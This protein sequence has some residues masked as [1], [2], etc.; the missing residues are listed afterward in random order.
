MKATRL[1]ATAVAAS[2]LLAGC[3]SGY[4]SDSK[5]GSTSSAPIRI[6]FGSSGEAETGAVKAAAAAWQ[7][8][9]GH[10]VQVIPAQNLAQQLTQGFAG[11][12]PPDIFYTDPTVLQQYAD[13]GS[14]YP[15]GD[16]LPKSTVDDFYPALKQAYTYQD[17]LYCAPK[18]LDTHE[19]VINTDLWKK[20]GL[21]AA[22]YPKTW[23]DL[24]RVATKLTTKDH[25]GL[26]VGGDHN[27]VGTFMLEAGGW[28]VNDDSTKVTADTPQN[29][30]ALKYL[31]T[32]MKKKIF[33]TPKSINTQNPGEAFGKGKAAMDVDGGWIIGQLSADYP[34]VNWTAVP[35]PAGPSGNGTTVFSNCWGIAAKSKNKKLAVDLVKSLTSVQQQKNFMKAF[36]ATP[37]RQS[38]A[39]WTVKENPK[40]TAFVRGVTTARGVVPIPGFGSVLGDFDTQLEKLF[41]GGTDPK[42][43]LTSLQRNGTDALK[44]K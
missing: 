24:T 27:T 34:G 15:Y 18:D 5:D 43:A 29:L 44:Q 30:A 2:L 10:K 26:T 38:L 31:Q 7:K 12:N 33:A 40:K 9:T 17:K 4:D 14:L 25:V 41:T 3:G 19:L 21:T 8:K 39:D 6:M 20:A 36:G 11:G 22:D 23:A 13:G 37:S 42:T 1:L 32:N 28:F 16:Q 35:M